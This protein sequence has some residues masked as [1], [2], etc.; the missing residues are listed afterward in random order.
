[1]ALGITA[2][3]EAAFSSE[4]SDVEVTLGNNLSLF[5]TFGQSTY[6]NP[7]ATLGT[8]D[9]TVSSVNNFTAPSATVRA[10][11]LYCAVDVGSF[12]AS[13]YGVIWETGGSVSG[14]AAS[15]E[16]GGQLYVAAYVGSSWQ[17]SGQAYLK[18]D[19]SSYYN[20]A[21]TFYTTINNTAKQFN[22]YFQ[23]GGPSSGN[24]A[25][26]LGTSTVGTGSE[27]AGGGN[28]G[29]GKP[30]L[31]MVNFG[32]ANYSA[33]FTGD[34]Q[35]L[36]FYYNTAEPSPFQTVIT[37]P[38]VT[39]DANTD[40]T[41]SQATITNGGAVAGS[42]VVV[43]TTGVS[44]QTFI[45][46]EDI[47]VGVHVTGIQLSITNKTSTQDT[48]TAFGEAPFASQSPATFFIPSVEVFTTTGAGQLPSFLLQTS[49]GEEI[50]TADANVPLTGIS[51]VSSIGQVDPAPD[52]AVTGIEMTSAIGIETISAEAN[53]DV[54]G[55]VLTSNI[56]EESS[57]GNAD[58]P[59][60]GS[61]LTLS[62]NDVSF[63]I[64]AD[65][66][67]TGS[68]ANISLG[69]YS[70][71]ADGNVSVIVT[72]HDIITSIGSVTTTAN[73]DVSVTGSQLTGSVGDVAFTITGSVAVTGQQLTLT[74][75]DEFAFTDVTAEVTGQE[76]TMSMG[77]ETP[78]ADA[79]VELTG[80]QLTSSIGTV[81]AVVVVEVTGV[82]MSTSIGS[83]TITGNANVDITG[84]Q[85][86]TNTGNPN[87][88]AWA[89]IDPGVSN[90]WT[91]IDPGVSNGW[92]EVDL[93]A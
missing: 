17:V 42:S 27:W 32:F 71:S 30:N 73:A 49:I 26:F 21:G 22:L 78:T 57:T 85:L 51:L 43:S 13:D 4:A 76:L 54:V 35:Q 31:T 67:V 24:Q 86:Q 34:A 16:A 80:I 37:T 29:L 93:A 53:V 82:Q 11:D 40:V 66:N 50:V 75:G 46:E 36:R 84:I 72:E 1:M 5:T 48:L 45:G 9:L 58:V 39:A 38:V 74:L 47:N 41:G 79:N 59:V 23:P 7:E 65:I 87:I 44:L 61:E 89:E 60:I 25:V 28:G 14:F 62:T 70:V 12:D 88:T 10:Q 90:V 3:S 55:S 20:T 52:V 19:V 2:Y 8:P 69:T 18:V 56:G 68:Q 64:T 6:S 91:E 33:L 15:L 77:E 83:V 81:D 63:E 92:T